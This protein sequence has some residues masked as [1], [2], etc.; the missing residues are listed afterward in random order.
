MYVLALL[1]S[2]SLGEHCRD[3]RG[4]VWEVL[5]GRCSY[6]FFLV[7]LLSNSSD[8]HVVGRG[9]SYVFFLLCRETVVLGV[10]LHSCWLSVFLDKPSRDHS[11]MFQRSRSLPARTD[12]QAPC[13]RRLASRNSRSDPR[14]SAHGPASPPPISHI[15]ERPYRIPPAN[16]APRREDPGEAPG[17]A[18]TA[19]DT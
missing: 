10:D 2:V 15:A 13:G 3:S 18:R 14:E 12:V 1:S 4:A 9:S 7:A 6:G 8:C 16:D 11:T 19:P 17:C 5:I